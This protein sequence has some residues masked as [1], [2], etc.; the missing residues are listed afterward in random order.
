ML[1]ALLA[2]HDARANAPADIAVGPARRALADGV[3]MRAAKGGGL[4]YRHVRAHHGRPRRGTRAVGRSARRGT[5]DGLGLRAVAK[6]F[7]AQ[8]FLYRGELPEAEREGREALVACQTFGLDLAAG[9]LHG[10]SPTP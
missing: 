7:R 6:I 5:P 3:L 8:T 10:T 9:Y 1:L 2:Y 4:P